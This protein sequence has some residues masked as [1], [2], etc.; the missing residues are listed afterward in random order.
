MDPAAGAP[1]LAQ[2]FVLSAV[3]EGQGSTVQP[4]AARIAII[5]DHLPHTFTE[6]PRFGRCSPLIYGLP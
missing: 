6:R 1:P 2:K 3:R 4:A 5:A